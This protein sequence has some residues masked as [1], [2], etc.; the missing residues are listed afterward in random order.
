MNNKITFI[1]MIIS[2]IL[3]FYLAFYGLSIDEF[4][5]LSI[6]QLKE[7]NTQLNDK[8]DEASLLLQN[9]YPQKEQNL[10][11]TYEKYT[12]QKQKYE[13]LVKTTNE[14]KNGI[15]ET[16]QYEVGYLWRILGNYANKRNLSL[17]ID[18]QKNSIGE[19]LYNIQFNVL[20]DYVKISQFIADI[21]NDSD[22]YFRIYNFK[23]A[24]GE[25]GEV[26]ATFLV[27]NVNLDIS[28]ISKDKEIIEE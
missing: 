21:E 13:E 20:G 7:K 1:I 14:S 15:Y 12:I 10:E 4:K 2:I 26:R 3:I 24:N 16:K 8:I 28:T 19:S 11:E 17:G 6:S 5:I 9:A 22:L 23:M 27:K 18:I 25:E